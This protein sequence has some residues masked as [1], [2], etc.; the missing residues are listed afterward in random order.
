[1]RG[2]GDRSTAAMQ[3][4][5]KRLGF[6]LWSYTR[7]KEGFWGSGEYELTGSAN[8]GGQVVSQRAERQENKG[9]EEGGRVR[10]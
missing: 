9:P 4:V 7:R 8:I 10:E 1:M 6:L 3:G 5:V 2:E